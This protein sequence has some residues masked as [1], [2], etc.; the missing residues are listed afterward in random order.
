MKRST[1]VAAALVVLTLFA[2]GCGGDDDGGGGDNAGTAS[3]GTRREDPQ[4]A[5]I[6]EEA[7]LTAS[8]LPAWW[9]EVDVDPTIGNALLE[10][11]PACEGLSAAELSSGTNEN[12]RSGPVSFQE[13]D[14]VRRL[15]LEISLYP[16][17]ADAEAFLTSLEESDAP[18]CIN[19][20][21]ANI[22]PGGVQEPASWSTPPA[23]GDQALAITF[24]AKANDT[25]PEDL[26]MHY[27]WVRV[28]RAVMQLIYIGPTADDPNT[29][30][31]TVS[32]RLSEEI[33]AS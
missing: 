22:V 12:A 6:A 8:D 33:A 29:Y 32:T 15:D 2:A 30:V 21:L 5:L 25:I 23:L 17:V 11:N 26:T 24:N 10:S 7:L 19:A 27:I 1:A 13:L 14:G 20:V 18:G 4:S 3:D 28:D 31:N 9:S 16:D